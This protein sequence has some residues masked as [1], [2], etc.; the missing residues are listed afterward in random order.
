VRSAVLHGDA[1]ATASGAHFDGG[2][3]YI[4][5]AGF[6]YTAGGRWSVGFWLTKEQVRRRPCLGF[7]R[8]AVSE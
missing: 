5:V 3:D 7:G 1:H 4:T 2:G 8:M 6:D